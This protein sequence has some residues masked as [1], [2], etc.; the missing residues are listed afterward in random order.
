MQIPRKISFHNM[1]SSPALE[2]RIDQKIDKLQA[3]FAGLI[4]CHVT[5]EGAHQHRHKGNTYG[6]H[7]LVTLPGGEKVVSHHPG[8]S[9]QRHQKAFAVM[10]DAFKAIEKQLAHYKQTQR[11]AVKGHT[12]ILLNGTVVGLDVGQEFG[13]VALADGTEFYF[14]RNA[15]HGD[16]YLD[17]GVGSKVRFSFVENEGDHGPQANLVKLKN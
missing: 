13:F 1:D 6:I 16:R 9:S 11:G 8:K 7:I 10:N 17:L 3:R 5:V 14:H 2:S 4:R 15:V 12:S